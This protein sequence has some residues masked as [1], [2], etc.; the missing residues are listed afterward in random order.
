MDYIIC[1]YHEIG[2]KGK[3]RKFFEEILV[4]NI[5]RAL[6]GA[7]FEFVKRISGRI[8][9]KLNEKGVKEK[10]KIRESLKNIFGIVHFSFALNCKQD[11]KVIKEK[12]LEI[13]EKKRFKSFKIGTQR[14]EKNFYLTSPQINEKVGAFIVKKLKKK[15]NLGNPG[16]TV[17]IEIV[18]KYAFLYSFKIKARGGLPLGSGG[19]A[20]AL[21]S[22]GIDSPVAA[23]LSMKRGIKVIFVH[24]HTHPYTDKASIEKVKDLVRV[25]N[26]FQFESKLYLVPFASIQKEILLKTP[27]K[28]RV[29]LYRRFM[30]RIARDIAVKERASA[31][32]TG[33]SVGQVASQTLENMKAIEEIVELPILRPLVS[34]DKEEI[35]KKAKD[36]G[37]FNISILPHQDC[38]IRFLPRHPEIRAD[39]KQ[40]K[41]AEKKLDIKGLIKNNAKEI[42]KLSIK[43]VSL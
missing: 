13:L 24:F 32:I 38:C 5:K 21:L 34:D 30:L 6:P 10:R 39:L 17:F 25:L 33:E 14:S 1:H 26:K 4:E 35:I 8:I 29:I 19:R 41:E 23:F 27:D 2:L 42:L 37:T 20:I 31:L 43:D 9:V 28:L 15:V 40:V 3:N 36:I 7:S 12:A 16:A 11:M 22:G 18:Q